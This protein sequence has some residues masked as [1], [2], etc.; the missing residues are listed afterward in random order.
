MQRS[1]D[2]SRVTIGIQA[3]S[4]SK[5]FPRK[6]FAMLGDKSVL[7]HVI[8]A[9]NGSADYLNRNASKNR[10]IS[11][12]A[13]CHPT[14]DEIANSFPAVV[15]IEGPEHDVLSRYMRLINHFGS[16]YV[17][18]VT[19]DC[20]LI[21]SFVITKLITCALMNQYDYVS[22]VEEHCRTAADGMDCEVISARLM[23]YLDEHAKEPADREHVTTF[24]RSHPPDWIRRGV[25]IN[26][27]DLSNYKLSLDT[28]EDHARISH[29]YEKIQN[30][31]TIAESIYG[32][33]N[34]HRF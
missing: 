34:V 32:R 22:N 33:K 14:G 30:A 31:L 28:P 11:N 18:R 26:F 13:I 15:K 3:R 10:A 8:D 23:R 25:I 27:L 7:Q 2:I 20:P 19:A 9:C 24:A 6:V 1:T 4:S 12:V 29:E 16:D 17:V 5:R 21:P